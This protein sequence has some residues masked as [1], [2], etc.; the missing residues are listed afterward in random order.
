MEP[1]LLKL[2]GVVECRIIRRV[3]RFVA[4]VEVGGGKYTAYVCNTGRLVEYFKAGRRGFCV[5][6]RPGLKTQLRLFAV[7]DM[8]LGALIDTQLQAKS[9]EEAMSRGL[10]PWLKGYKIARRNPRLGG[11]VL[12][13]V[14]TRDGDSLLVEVKSA[15][16]RGASNY[17]MYPD[18]PSVRGRRQ[19]RELVKLAEKGGKGLVIFLACLPRVRGFKPNED[20]DPVIAELLREAHEGGVEVRALSLYYCPVDSSIRLG[21]PDLEVFL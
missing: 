8:G 19:L 15:V 20:A 9:F 11:S 6:N 17:A 1:P 14:L 3:N 21:D 18:C 4:E 12:D 10:L 13:Y 5:W 16:L 2:A 7:E